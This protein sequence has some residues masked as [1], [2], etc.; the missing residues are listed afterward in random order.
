[1]IF[2]FI[3]NSICI[4]QMWIY[5]LGI[6]LQ[7]SIA[8]SDDDKS[9]TLTTSGCSSHNQ[10][11]GDPP[12]GVVHPDRDHERATG[13]SANDT[14]PLAP[15]NCVDKRSGHPNWP[16]TNLPIT[17]KAPA[18]RDPHSA[19]RPSPQQ[20]GP[21]IHYYPKQQPQ[22][23]TSPH[24]AAVNNVMTS[25]DTVIAKMCAVQLHHRASLM[26]LLNVSAVFYIIIIIIVSTL[27]VRVL[28]EGG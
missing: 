22:L 2:D 7:C 19:G 3:S 17:T 28:D 9:P 13:K 14:A 24:E 8:S 4:Q 12:N 20:A 11:R 21:G 1:M 16:T 23:A 26:Y 15:S 25:L 10:Q 5:S 27:V 6:T 18:P